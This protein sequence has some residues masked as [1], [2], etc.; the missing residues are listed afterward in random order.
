LS[1]GRVADTV[2][3]TEQT[4]AGIGEAI[5]PLGVDD[6]GR[7]YR[8]HKVGTWQTEDFETQE[9]IRKR[10]DVTSFIVGAGTYTV[11]F[12]YTKGWWGL[13][14]RRTALVAVDEDGAE[15]EVAADAHPGSAGAHPK[16]IAYRL[17][18]DQQ[19]AQL[20]YFLVAD[21]Q[22]VTSKGK[23]EN[24]QGCCGELWMAKVRP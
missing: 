10:W 18:L 13:N 11:R 21:I 6:P 22:G 19:D 24:R 16:D 4:I 7:A 15:R 5:S 2:N 20:K 12:D 14:I 8:P 17:R 9:A 1:K 23:P 3:V